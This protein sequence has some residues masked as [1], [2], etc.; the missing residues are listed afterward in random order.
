MKTHAV[1]KSSQ[2]MGDLKQIV[3][4]KETTQAYGLSIDYEI[5]AKV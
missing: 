5:E 2:V 3:L 4:W 1:G